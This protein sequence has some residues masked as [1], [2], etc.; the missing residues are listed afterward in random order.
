[1]TPESPGSASSLAQTVAMR[2]AAICE[3]EA[4]ALAGS[5]TAQFTDEKSD[6]DLYV[7]SRETIPTF[8]RAKIPCQAKRAEIGNS[9]WEPGDEWIDRE[10][11][12]AVDVMFRTTSW[13]EEQLNRVLERHEASIGYSTCFWY[14]VRNSCALVDSSGWFRVLQQRAEEQPYP[15]ELKR[16]IVAKN[17]P[18]LRGTISSYLHQIELAF[19]RN[20]SVSVNHRVAALLA[21]YFDIVFA[22]NEQPHP[23]EKRLLQF[24]ETLCPKLP[25][26]MAERVQAL[27]SD[28]ANESLVDR[29]NR[30]LDGLDDWLRATGFL[31]SPALISKE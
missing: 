16:A 13:I 12:V 23:G 15:Q 10:T 19:R 24:A 11:G 18:V 2:F 25:P 6:I 3:V 22:L 26:D 9:F 5:R 21:S 17:H 4:V 29:A 7:Y 31:L 14:N 27:L 20:D 1:M 28:L 30:L 8:L